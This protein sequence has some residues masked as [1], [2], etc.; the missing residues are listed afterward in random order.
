[1]SSD[2]KRY[3]F[4]SVHYMTITVF[5]TLL[6]WRIY[7]CLCSHCPSSPTLCP[8]TLPC[9]CT[10]AWILPIRNTNRILKE[11]R[12]MRPGYFLLCSL[13]AGQLGACGS[14][15][16]RSYSG[17]C[18]HNLTAQHF[19]VLSFSIFTSDL[20]SLFTLLKTIHPLN[21]S[22]Q[23]AQVLVSLFA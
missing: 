16:Q 4:L 6:Y 10:S 13:S 7:D 20:S 2:N 18:N 21:S 17:S 5:K 3:C 12:R 1:M 11:E 9:C 19:P 8:Y 23:W 14:L 15:T 22:S